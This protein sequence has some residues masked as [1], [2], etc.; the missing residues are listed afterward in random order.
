M[1]ADLKLKERALEKLHSPES[2]HAGQKYQA[3]DGLLQFLN[4]L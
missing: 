1:V 4:S 3:S 2:N